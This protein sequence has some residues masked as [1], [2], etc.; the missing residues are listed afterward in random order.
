MNYST[1]KEQSANQAREMVPEPVVGVH[2][3]SKRLSDL[4]ICF[5]TIVKSLNPQTHLFKTGN[6]LVDDSF[7]CQMRRIDDV[8]IL[9]DDER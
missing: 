2:L 7:D 5:H 9:R 3:T 4:A 1:T 6:D 8:R